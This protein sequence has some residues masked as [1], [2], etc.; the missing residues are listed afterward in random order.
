MYKRQA[1]IS[2]VP[3]VEQLVG[4]PG[5]RL[6]CR[7]VELSGSMLGLCIGSWDHGAGRFAS[8]SYAIMLSFRL[9]AEQATQVF[10]ANSARE[11]R[12]LR[13]MVDHITTLIRFGARMAPKPPS[14]DPE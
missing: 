11:V 1:A 2:Y 10:Q 7:V 4:P 3:L 13:D 5:E 14:S 12:G 8:L 9:D 6:V